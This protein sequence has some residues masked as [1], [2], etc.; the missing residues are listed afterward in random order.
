MIDLTMEENDKQYFITDIDYDDKE[1]KV[2]RADGS[3]TT[4]TFSSHNLGFYRNRMIENA[5]DNI[6]PYMDDLSKDSFFTFVKKYSAFIGGIVGLFFLY[7]I[8]IH[9]I[10]KIIITLLVLITELGYYIYNELYLVVL[11]N[12]VLECLA[13]EYYLNNLNAFKYFDNVNYTDGFI[14]PPEDIGKYRLSKD[15]LEQI[16]QL[17]N[18]YKK[19]GFEPSE[20]SMTYKRQTGNGKNMV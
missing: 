10:M 20:M 9:I 14:V 5:S 6:G 4:E 19:Q 8:D 16:L 3:I 18:N 11:G 17:I 7:N 1:I 15:M 12:E 2:T 13:T